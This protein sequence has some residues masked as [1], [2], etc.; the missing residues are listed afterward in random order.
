MPGVGQGD[1]TG[2]DPRRRGQEQSDRDA[3]TEGLG[4]AGK[5]EDKLIGQR[6]PVNVARRLTDKPMIVQ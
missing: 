3:G 2:K 6:R 1:E 4:N 5:E